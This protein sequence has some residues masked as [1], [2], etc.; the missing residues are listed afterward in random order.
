VGQIQTILNIITGKTLK[1][2]KRR[3]RGVAQVGTR[4]KSNSISKQDLLGLSD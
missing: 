4:S 3:R 1:K 2:K